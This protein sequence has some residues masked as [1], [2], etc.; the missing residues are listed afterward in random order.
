MIP[1]GFIV[2]WKKSAPWKNDYQIEQ[3]LI[4]ERALVDIFSDKELYEQLAFRGGTAL[5]KLFLKPQVR[6]SEDID[7]VQVEEG[8]IGDVLTLIREKL[9]F[10]GV[11]NYKL[12][13][14]NATL[15]YKF[16]SETE[17]VI[18]QKLKIEINTREHFS[19]FGYKDYQ[20]SVKSDWFNGDCRVKSY[21]I[22][23]LLSTKMR[24][25]FQRRKGRD[26]FDI[27]YAF[28]KI[29]L[30]SQNILKGLK[31]YLAKE[32]LTI[33][34]NDFLINM[35][36]KILDTEFIGDTTALLR[37]EIKYDHL[38][39]WNFIKEELIEKLD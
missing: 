2:Q 14:H 37:T 12:T 34:K 28:Q 3:D 8:S 29:K 6:Y 36:N 16:E 35:E 17:P 23:E 21:S 4:I 27:Y 26:L 10:V 32:N 13:N 15:L 9:S 11:A 18:K 19:V 25:L 38:E 33:S 22:E 1:R 31:E 39:A 20:H 7:L 5:H 24:A 30:D